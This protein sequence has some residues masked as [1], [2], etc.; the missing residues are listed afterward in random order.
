MANVKISK[1]HFLIFDFAKV[2]GTRTKVTNSQKD[3]HTETDKPVAI[4]E[5]KNDIDCFTWS[6]HVGAEMIIQSA[7]EMRRLYM[8]S[9]CDYQFC[10]IHPWS[11]Y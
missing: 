11:K 7:L 3:T 10:V 6:G 5:L 8:I 4:A 2:Q 9:S 1:R